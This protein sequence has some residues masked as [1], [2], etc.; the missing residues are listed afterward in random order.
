MHFLSE[1]NLHLILYLKQG[2]V[3]YHEHT[4]YTKTILSVWNEEFD[5]ASIHKIYTYHRLRDFDQHDF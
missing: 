3:R 4:E 1:G 5:K 2:K